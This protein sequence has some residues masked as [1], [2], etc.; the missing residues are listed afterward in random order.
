M[1]LSSRALMLA[2][3]VSLLLAGGCATETSGPFGNAGPELHRDFEGW[4]TLV[5][6]PVDQ[7]YNASL[8]GLRDL[9]IKP[10]ICQ[11][12]KVSASVDGTFADDVPFEVRVEAVSLDASRLT[13]KTGFFGNTSRA[14]LLYQAICKHLMGKEKAEIGK[15][16]NR[17]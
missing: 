12:D 10:F 6:Q 7:V 1:N 15:A 14:K 3:A 9:G 17:N 13:I 11:M 8:A 2:G 16:E 4:H 5:R